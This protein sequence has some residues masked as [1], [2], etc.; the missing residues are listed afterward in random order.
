MDCEFGLDSPYDECKEIEEGLRA[1]FI[2]VSY[3]C[4]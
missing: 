2:A 1:A 4:G 3:H